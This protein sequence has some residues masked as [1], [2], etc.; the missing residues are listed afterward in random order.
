MPHWVSRQKSRQPQ[1]KGAGF[2]RAFPPNH[3]LP[4]SPSE[5]P[6]T[7]RTSSSFVPNF[8]GP[9]VRP[10]LGG[11]PRILADSCGKLIMQR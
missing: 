6:V 10:V 1:A 5:E 11:F 3:L 9:S 7:T 2:H 8:T 4:A